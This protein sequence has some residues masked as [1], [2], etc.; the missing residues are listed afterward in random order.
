MA[1]KEK[2]YKKAEEESELEKRKAIEEEMEK[3][4]TQYKAEAD[5]RK[6]QEDE[7]KKQEDDAKKQQEYEK[8][9]Q[10]EEKKEYGKK[11]QDNQGESHALET[12]EIVKVY[13]IKIFT[14]KIN[15]PEGI[16]RSFLLLNFH[17]DKLPQDIKNRIVKDMNDGVKISNIYVSRVFDSVKNTKKMSIS[18]FKN[19][20]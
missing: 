9:K 5:E 17:P 4:L 3:K 18:E 8:K 19:L 20:L 13:Y 16:S 14:D 6:K 1:K 10:E 7:K 12:I 15:S 2:D 11:K